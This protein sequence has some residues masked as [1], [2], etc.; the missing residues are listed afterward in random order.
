MNR[1]YTVIVSS[2]LLFVSVGV[3]PRVA[4]AAERPTANPPAV[5]GQI[6]FSTLITARNVTRHL[7]TESG[8]RDLARR[9][10][11]IGIRRVW[12]EVVRGGHLVKSATLRL[13]RDLFREEG[14]IA[15][16]AVTTTWGPG[17]GVK[18]TGRHFL[19]YSAPETH[20][21]LAKS[22][23]VA[24]RVFDEIMVDDFLA[25]QCRCD[26]CTREK[27]ERT[28]A[29][30]R[31]ELRSRVARQFIVEPIH[32]ANSDAVVIIKFPQ[33]YDRFHYYGYDVIRDTDSFDAIWVGTETRG[34]DTPR[35]GYV[36][37]YQSTI[38][39]RWLRSIAGAKTRGGWFDVYD[40]TPDEYVDQAYSTVLAGAT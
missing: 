25:T 14:L 23:G 31:C 21:A 11:A 17:F 39:Y 7:A 13:A 35:F 16:G 24:A 9:L 6:E 34:P 2:L 28:W 8:A 4:A 29:E 1:D 40:C 27:G 10:R 37:T 3:E 32:E 5:E 15:S 19:C 20:Q 38:V 30:Y 36:P 12:I 26:R 18:S 33:W 22:A